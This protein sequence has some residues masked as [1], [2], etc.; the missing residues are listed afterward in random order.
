M[1]K[2]IGCID[3]FRGIC[4]VWMIFGHLFVWWMDYS[5]VPFFYDSI[6]PLFEPLG[7]A[8]FIFI[9]G[10]SLQYSYSKKLNESEIEKKIDNRVLRNTYFIRATILLII[11][12]FFNLGTYIQEPGISHI[13]SWWILFTISITLFL[14]WPLMKTS[15]YSRFIIG[16]LILILNPILQT[17]LNTYSTWSPLIHIINQFLYPIDDRQNPLIPFLP[18]FIFGSCLGD[19]IKDIDFNR[20]DNN[21][22]FLRKFSYPLIF[23]SIFLILFGIFFQFPLFILRNSYTWVIYSLGFMILVFTL[24]IISEKFE[25]INF[26]S[27]YN[28]LFYYSYYSFSIY[29]VTFI[30]MIFPVPKLNLYNFWFFYFLTMSLTTIALKLIYE[31]VKGLFSI[32]YIMSRVSEF[33]TLKIEEKFYNQEVIKISYLIE[34]LKIN[35]SKS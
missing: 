15:I 33:L 10:V 35:L 14:Y 23:L 8:G 17:L 24:L 32:K 12:I 7:A 20:Y 31:S 11:A 21:K 26:D 30:F 5:Y 16:I 19:L 18:F 27:K 13:F 9:S 4:I 22:T 1:K 34:R 28:F 25:F 3:F 2:R 6:V 29:L